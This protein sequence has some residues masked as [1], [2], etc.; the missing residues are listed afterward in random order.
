MS[1]L[2]SSE[3]VQ[4][5]KEI[6]SGYV[7]NNEVLDYFK[8]SDFVVIAGPAGAGKDTLRDGLINKYPES[9]MAAICDTTRPP[10]QNESNGK[11]YYFKEIDD[12]KKSFER[13]E[14]FQAA[15]IHDQQICSLHVNEI[16]RLN[17]NQHA[18]S[19]LVPTTEAEL[20]DIKNDIKTI[21]LIPPSGDVLIDRI[22]EGRSLGNEEIKRRL[23]AA[24]TEIEFAL[25]SN[26]Y[27]CIVSDT[28]E[29]V[30]DKAHNYLQNGQYDS[31]SSKRARTV[32]KQVMDYLSQKI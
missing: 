24:Y 21:F 18:L 25:N 28:K 10:R 32:M 29:S 23:K 16:M 12:V 6:L 14:Y 20:R 11:T 17:P 30:L 19:I 26:N 31:E 22:N 9:Y 1:R 13:R 2:L 3:E 5:F 15:L 27:F 8:N 7:P 4:E